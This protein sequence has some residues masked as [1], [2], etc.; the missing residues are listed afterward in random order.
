[1][2]TKDPEIKK[3][4]DDLKRKVEIDISHEY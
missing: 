3:L 2:K 1:V 4:K